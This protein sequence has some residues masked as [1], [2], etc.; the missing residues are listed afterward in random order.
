MK[1]LL[2]AA[3]AVF[4][5]VSINAQEDDS[6]ASETNFGLKGGYTSL[7]LKVS[8]EGNSA[9]DN[10][11]GF[12]IGAFAEFN[13]SEKFMIQPEVVFASYSED[14]ESSGVLMVPVLGKYM[15][16]ED[17]GILFGP[18]FDY[19]TNEEDSEGLKRFGIGLA[20]GA[21]VDVSDEVYIDARY[22]FGISNRIDGDLEGLEG[23]DITARF[24]YLQIGIGYRL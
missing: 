5:F 14:G 18:Q 7:T 4:S 22:T 1:R 20:L 23:F 10:V 21:S 13:A 15:A 11:G 9:S 19:L 12:Y 24:N 8:A 6:V 2:F 17:F 16:N 3:L